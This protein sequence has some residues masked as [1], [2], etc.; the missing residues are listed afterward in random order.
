MQKY[1]GFC[2]LKKDII[3]KAFLAKVVIG[4]RK[5]TGQNN[6]YF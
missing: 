2:H 3:Y 1:F 5:E 6:R 4:E